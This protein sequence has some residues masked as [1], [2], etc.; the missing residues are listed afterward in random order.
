MAKK[1]KYYAV[2]NT[3]QIFEDWSD[4]E[5]V[6]KGTKGVEFKSFPTK[7]QAEAYLKEQE[8]EKLRQNS[9]QV[10]FSLTPIVY[11]EN[12]VSIDDRGNL[13]IKA[14]WFSLD[15]A[16]AA[17]ENYADFFREKGTGSI[18]K[19]TISLSDNPS[20]GTVSV[21]NETVVRK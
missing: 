13:R 15:D 7:E 11:Y 18:R 21:H 20:Q 14:R 16:I 6:V 2:R 8:I 9:S 19:V 5:R 17:M 4:C 10:D 3:N 1:K 12:L